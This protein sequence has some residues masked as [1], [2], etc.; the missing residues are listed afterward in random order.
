MD[1]LLLLAA[2]LAFA[3]MGSF[4][5]ARAETPQAAQN[6]EQGLVRMSD[7]VSGGLL[8]PTNQPG[9]F[10]EAPRVATDFHVTISGP[11]AR[12]RVTQR[13]TNPTDGWVEGIY[14]FPLPTDS[15]VDT[16][17]MRIGDRL[18]EGEIR[19]RGEARRIYEEA[20]EA[21]QRASLVEQQRPNLFTNSVANIG[22]GET[23][24][25]Q[26]EYQESLRLVSNSFELRLPLVVAPRYNPLPEVTQSVSI[27]ER[28]GFAVNDPVPDREAITPPVLN[29]EVA[30]PA[31]PVTI[32]IDLEAGFPLGAVESPYHAITTEED[33]DSHRVIRL[34]EET[35]PANRDFVLTWKPAEGNA[36]TAALF[37]ETVGG[38]GYLLAYVMPPV[39]APEGPAPA[40]ELVLVIDNSGSMAGQSIVQARESV[41]FALSRLTPRDRFNIVRF[42]D[43]L[44]VLFPDAVPAD[45]ENIDRAR[46]YVE[47]LDAEGGTEML[48]ALVAAL[49]D[50]NAQAATLRQIVFI[51]DGAIGNES[52]LF[53]T[54]ASGLGRSRVFTVGIGSAP[55]SFF[56]TRAA[57]LG[58]GT[59][60]HIGSENEVRGKMEELFARL[61]TPAATNLQVRVAGG[62]LS[63][64][65]PNPLPDLYL[66]EPLMV[67]ARGIDGT[68]TLEITGTL[69]GQPWRV[70]LDLAH[71][72]ER[73][74]I[75]RL[76]GRRRIASLEAAASMG[77]ERSD[78]DRDILST[79]LE[80]GIVSRLTSLVAVDRTPARPD[81]EPLTS[82]EV[83][84]NLPEGWDFEAVFGEQEAAPAP[85]PTI[86]AGNAPAASQ[87]F[88]MV[89]TAAAP[90][91]D[92]AAAT[93]TVATPGIVLPSTATPADRLMLMG[94][95]TMLLSGMLGLLIVVW[96]RA[97]SLSMTTEHRVR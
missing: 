2:A 7:V 76:Y 11:V 8:L 58:R 96:R 93:G 36:P 24:V 1:A 10:I 64:I 49:N 94:I 18:I 17:R 20:R 48:P 89:T 62:T 68:G 81:G 87:R 66:G 61:E 59:F 16:L 3:A 37:S 92:A 45:R 5:E 51:T 27:D 82:S 83:P 65:A 67:T 43:T 50:R 84:V 72:A 88:A 47:R 4:A 23:V 32:T 60:T 29:P 52:Q 34:S 74:G 6:A 71:A 90:A 44:T 13:F 14:V 28:T 19:E 85:A 78:V 86:R 69:A 63:D 53:Q 33:G 21:G 12:T 95:L 9:L 56:M 80:F 35:V 57:E 41:L 46:R 26:I 40:R 42:D 77:R 39:S 31:N 38:E 70:S 22:P 25:V 15:A 55:N 54:I 30:P 79:A 91:A 75:A 73:E 97:A